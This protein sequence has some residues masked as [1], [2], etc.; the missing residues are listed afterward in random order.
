MLDGRVLVE[1]IA[2]AQLVDNMEGLSAHRAKNG[3]LIF[4]LISDDNYN[5][6]LQRTLLLQFA[7]PADKQQGQKTGGS[8]FWYRFGIAQ[9]FLQMRHPGTVDVENSLSPFLF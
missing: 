9:D 7:W 4:T 8:R 1:A 6:S 3:D 5:R 2:P